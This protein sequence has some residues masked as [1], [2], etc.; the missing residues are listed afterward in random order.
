MFSSYS[1]LGAAWGMTDEELLRRT[2][3]SYCRELQGCFTE[4]RYYYWKNVT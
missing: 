3:E 2:K 1:L 4:Q